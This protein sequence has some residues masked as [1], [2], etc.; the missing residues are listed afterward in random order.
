MYNLFCSKKHAQT[1]KILLVQWRCE[2]F[3]PC[4]WWLSLFISAP[5]GSSLWLQQCIYLTCQIPSQTTHSEEIHHVSKK[6]VPHL[7]CYNFDTHKR[8]LILFGRNDTDEVGNQN[9]LHYA[10]SS[11]L[12]FCTTW[13]NGET[14]KSHFSLSWTVLHAQRTRVLSSWKNKL[15]SVM[16]LIAFNIC[17]DSKI[18]H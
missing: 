12:C 14:Q 18:S 9:T 6:N 2:T 13:Q 3:I 4:N 15:S 17:W 8:I 7:A 10:T 11:N 16:C 1:T 5:L